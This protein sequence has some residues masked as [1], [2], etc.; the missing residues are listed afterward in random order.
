MINLMIT[1]AKETKVPTTTYTQP[2]CLHSPKH[3]GKRTKGLFSRSNLGKELSQAVGHGCYT[4]SGYMFPGRW[5]EVAQ[6]SNT[7]RVNVA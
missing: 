6:A 2:L 3:R 7:L 1:I 5:Q 4:Y